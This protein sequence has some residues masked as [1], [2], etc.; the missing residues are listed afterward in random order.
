MKE[1]TPSKAEQIEAILY[2]VAY[3]LTM[4]YAGRDQSG[5]PQYSKVFTVTRKEIE[6]YLQ[7][8]YSLNTLPGTHSSASHHDG[9]YIMSDSSGYRVY[10]Q[11]RGIKFAEKVVRSE[12]EVWQLYVDWNLR[13]S[14]TGLKWK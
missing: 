9:L 5:H 3:D 10:H 4:K 1:S 13:T 12:E 6:E 8:H 7:E 2:G 11:E 14:G